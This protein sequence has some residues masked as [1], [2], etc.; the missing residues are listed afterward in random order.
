MYSGKTSLAAPR[1]GIYE[2]VDCGIHGKRFG[3]RGFSPLEWEREYM[4]AQL[5]GPGSTWTR[6]DNCEA[7]CWNVIR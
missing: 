4:Y 3:V 2:Q 5:D 1:E 6:R 7:S